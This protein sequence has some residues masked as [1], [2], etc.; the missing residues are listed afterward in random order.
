M[1]TIQLYVRRGRGHVTTWSLGLW[2]LLPISHMVHFAPSATR[3]T[4]WVMWIP[5]KWKMGQEI[6]G[7]SV[8]MINNRLIIIQIVRYNFH[9]LLMVIM[10]NYCEF[11]QRLGL[12]ALHLWV[13]YYQNP[14][15]TDDTKM[16]K[17]LSNVIINSK[18]GKEPWMSS[19]TPTPL[20][21]S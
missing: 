19:L 20:L 4:W 18:T 11:L 2:G 8:I 14:Q 7:D 13:G 5:D 15:C 16:L 10:N 6:L 12:G 17:N 21:M 9:Q 1:W 3:N